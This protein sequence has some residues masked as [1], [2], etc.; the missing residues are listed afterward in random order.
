MFDFIKKLFSKKE[1]EKEIIKLENLND[2][3]NAKSN[4]I[5]DDLNENINLIKNKINSEIEKTKSNLEKLKEAKLQNPNIP[6]KA[7]QMM[8][9][10]RESYIKIILK[11]IN[12]I[13]LETD[14]KEL[15]IYCNGFDNYLNSLG[16]STSKS[17]HIT[18]YMNCIST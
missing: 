18:L 13:Y 14:Y 2:W 7:K 11:F 9:G 4:L 17:Y 16:K 12:N 6:I 10:N 15:L 8:E 3:F 5:Y 1:P